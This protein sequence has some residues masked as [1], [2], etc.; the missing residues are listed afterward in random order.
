[1]RPRPQREGESDQD[2]RSM[3]AE[4]DRKWDA[5]LG[6]TKTAWDREG[7]IGPKRSEVVNRPT[8]ESLESR[9]RDFRSNRRSDRGIINQPTRDLKPTYGRWQDQELPG[10]QIGRRPK[11]TQG[12]AD[13]LNERGIKPN[14][15]RGVVRAMI[16]YDR[17]G[18]QRPGK[19]IGNEGRRREPSRFDTR[20]SAD[21]A[22]YDLLTGKNDRPDTSSY[23]SRQALLTGNK[24]ASDTERMNL[25]TGGY[26][27]VKKP[28]ADEV[29]SRWQ[30]QYGGREEYD[31]QD[32]KFNQQFSESPRGPQPWDSPNKAGDYDI[33]LG[34]WEPQNNYN[35]QD[36]DRTQ[37]GGIVNQPTQDLRDVNKRLALLEGRPQSTG[38]NWQEDRIAALENRPQGTGGN[39]NE[40]RIKAL[41][42]R[43]QGGGWQEDRVSQL[44]KKPWW[45][46]ERVSAIESRK[47][48]WQEDRIAQLEGRQDDTSW[49]NPLSQVQTTQ[50]GYGTQLGNLQTGQTEGKTAR[51]GL[52]TRLGALENYYKNDPPPEESVGNRYE[53]KMA[54]LNKMWEQTGYT[55]DPEAQYEN[56]DWKNERVH[57]KHGG[58]WAANLPD[59]YVK[60]VRDLNKEY[61]KPT[62]TEIIKGR[63][64]KAYGPRSAA[65]LGYLDDQNIH[66]DTYLGYGNWQNQYGE[67]VEGWQQ[68]SQDRYFTSDSGLDRTSD[69]YKKRFKRG[70]GKDYAYY[71]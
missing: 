22:R 35:R 8:R 1:M 40:D 63:E 2:Y 32:R 50:A 58:T 10:E 66:E 5:R 21:Q 45:Q 38:G 67:D 43:P 46:E 37:R 57:G 4:M 61:N 13:F 65:R 27:P 19:R 14:D 31:P 39:W 24:L 59:Q 68:G 9:I 12:A 44:E 18:S 56:T 51:S 25:L 23:E 33:D 60:G 15:S 48:S 36:P 70:S 16:D 6:R 11:T 20:P 71:N 41:E 30:S 55:Y 42:G 17:Q 28:L 69:E 49:K 3:V 29:P 62:K 34:T 64:Y 52:D 54:N 47:P 26:D 7:Q 53:D